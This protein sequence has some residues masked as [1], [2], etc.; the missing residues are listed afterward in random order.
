[1]TEDRA[2][3]NQSRELLI[4]IINAQPGISFGELE[5]ITGLNDGTLRYH[6]GYL[7]KAD[8]ISSRKVGR[9][10]LYHTFDISN[11]KT[12]I[13]SR[14]TLDQ[15]RILNLIKRNPGIGS[16]EILNNVNLSRKGLVNIIQKLRKVSL[17][18]EVQNGNETGFEYVT[19]ERMVEELQLELV[20]R[21]L[22]GKNDQAT[23]MRLKKWIE[24]HE[25][26]TES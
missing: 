3:F 20:E 14:L 24:E 4:G 7:E 8:L 16:S 11:R 10:R 25:I 18:F 21:L 15:K 12:S 1:M 2:Q 5:K 23:F 6:L 22:T 19:R 13:E 17:V 9:M 26:E